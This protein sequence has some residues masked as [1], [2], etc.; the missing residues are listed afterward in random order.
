MLIKIEDEITS[1]GEGTSGQTELPRKKLEQEFYIQ[2]P[3]SRPEQKRI[4]AIPDGAFERIDTAIA[5]TQ[6]NLANARELFESYLNNVFSQKEE[7][8]EEK[9]I[10]DLGDVFDGPHATPETVDSGPIFL[11]ISTLHDEKIVLGE[12][13]HVTD[14]DYEKWTRRVKPRAGD[15][16]FSYETRL[17]QPALIPEGLECFLGRR[18]GLVRLDRKKVDPRFFVCMYVSPPF[19]KYLADRS[20]RGATVDRIPLK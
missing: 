13:R 12:T 4:V 10:G 2:Y 19:R 1:S 14:I 15:I 9:Q 17:G 7:G 5:N 3:T 6:K 11:G 16:V 20:I 18:M 8:W